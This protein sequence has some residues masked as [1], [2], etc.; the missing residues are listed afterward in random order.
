M[1]NDGKHAEARKENRWLGLHAVSSCCGWIELGGG[2]GRR[3]REAEW[4]L[5]WHSRTLLKLR[6]ANRPRRR[7]VHPHTFWPDTTGRCWAERLR[8]FWMRNTM[9]AT[10]DCCYCGAITLLPASRVWNHTPHWVTKCSTDSS[11]IFNETKKQKSRTRNKG[12]LI[13]T[14]R[15][16]D[17]PVAPSNVVVLW[18]CNKICTYL[19]LKM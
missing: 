11:S 9:T 10:E 5:C 15:K 18:K 16:D 1:E 14:K 4:R 8:D 3:R 13:K 6:L 19:D 17:D 7:Q 12:Q 2:G